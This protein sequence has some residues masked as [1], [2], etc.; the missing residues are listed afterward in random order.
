LSVYIE[1]KGPVCHCLG[2]LV[3]YVLVGPTRPLENVKTVIGTVDTNIGSPVATSGELSVIYTDI[4]TSI[5]DNQEMSFGI[6]DNYRVTQ[7]QATNYCAALPNSSG[8][9]AII[10]AAGSPS[11]ASMDLALTA[12]GLPA[13]VNGIFY[14]GTGQLGVPFGDGFRCVGGTVQR[15]P[16]GQHP[17]VAQVAR[18]ELDHREGP[19]LALAPLPLERVHPVQDPGLHRS[20]YE[21]SHGSL[22]RPHPSAGH[23]QD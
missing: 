12:T 19:A 11:V 20:G 22:R 23:R 7:F 5:S 6:V 13:G 2:Q 17:R 8:N 3:H 10:S 21:L 9:T 1:R 14:Y 16:I 4:F 18:L 15:L